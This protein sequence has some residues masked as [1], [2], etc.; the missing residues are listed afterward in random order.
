MTDFSRYH[1]GEGDLQLDIFVDE[2]G[3]S[4]S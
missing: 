4:T 2:W 3:P 1:Q